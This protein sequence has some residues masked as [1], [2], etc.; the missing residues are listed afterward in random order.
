MKYDA[1]GQRT[2]KKGARG[3]DRL[4]QP[5]LHP[6]TQRHRHQSMS[7]PA[8]RESRASSC[9]GRPQRQPAEARPLREGP[10]LHHHPRPPGLLVLCDRPQRSSTAPQYFPFGELEWSRLATFNAPPTCSLQRN[11]TRRRSCITS[12]RG[13]TTRGRDVWQSADRYWGC[14]CR[15]KKRCI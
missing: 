2:I 4:R 5:V 13:I 6:K 11:W 7:T 14:I 10:L 3:R 12:G 1:D 8:T 15:G 9:A